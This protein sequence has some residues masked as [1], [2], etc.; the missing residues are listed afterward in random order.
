MFGNNQDKNGSTGAVG[1]KPPEPPELKETLE[2]QGDNEDVTYE[3]TDDC[4]WKMMYR[5]KGTRVT[6]PAGTK[7]PW[8]KQVK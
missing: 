7:V 5:S 8:A 6:V 4:T 1:S 3:F 2:V